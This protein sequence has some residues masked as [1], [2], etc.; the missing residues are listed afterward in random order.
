[1]TDIYEYQ[2]IVT[3]PYNIIK[4]IIIIINI[5]KIILSIPIIF[6]KGILSILLFIKN[7]FTNNNKIIEELQ[8]KLNDINK[9][10]ICLDNTISNCCI[11]C[12]HTYCSDC[13]NKT[14]NC[15]ICRSIIINKI[16]IYL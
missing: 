12:G 1:M 8:T 11:P 3:I 16:K 6:I 15:Y 10:S 4:C 13:I 14:N 2:I 5:I 9:C 7:T